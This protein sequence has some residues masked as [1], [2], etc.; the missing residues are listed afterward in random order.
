MQEKR[1]RETLIS[2]VLPT[3]STKHD[4]R[5]GRPVDFGDVPEAELPEMVKSNPEWMKATAWMRKCREK[6]LERQKEMERRKKVGLPWKGLLGA[7]GIK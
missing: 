5:F 1:I 3:M 2:E 6:S 7:S 4:T